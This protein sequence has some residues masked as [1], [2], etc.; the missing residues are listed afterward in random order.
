M[1]EAK[2]EEDSLFVGKI[3]RHKEYDPSAELCDEFQPGLPDL[4]PFLEFSCC[5]FARLFR[6]LRSF[7]YDRFR[8]ETVN[9][10]SFNRADESFRSVAC[11]LFDDLATLSMRQRAHVR[12][13]SPIFCSGLC[14]HILIDK[15]R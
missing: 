12:G 9:E 11:D 3:I 15:L 8:K 13:T 7:T 2:D 6:E 4:S 1:A 14:S 10:A 5:I